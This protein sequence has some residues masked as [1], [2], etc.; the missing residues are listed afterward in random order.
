MA[1]SWSSWRRAG[2]FSRG[3]ESRRGEDADLAHAAAEH[4]AVDAG[5]FDE[6]AGTDDHGADGSTEAFGKTEHDGIA[7]PG[8]VGDVVVESDSGIEDA[9]SIEVNFQAEGVSLIAN[10]VDAIGGINGAAGHVAGIFQADERGLGVVIN[11][12]ANGGLDLCAK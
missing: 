5:A 4:L 7:F 9:G 6:F 10:F 3:N 1:F 8:H 2:D 12:G 11:L